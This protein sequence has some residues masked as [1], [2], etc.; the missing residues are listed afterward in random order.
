[1]R[2]VNERLNES[3]VHLE[4]MASELASELTRRQEMRH[5]EALAASR[6]LGAEV[7]DAH[8]ML[9]ALERAEPRTRLGR[10]ESRLE[11]LAHELEHRLAQHRAV[12]YVSPEREFTGWTELGLGPVVGYRASRGAE[13][14]PHYVE[15]EATFRGPEARVR[16]IQGAYI[17]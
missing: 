2:L 7:R 10:M 16:D 1:Q 11:P 12:P 15:F 13:P 9:E 5:A 14:R 4:E 17:P 3:V 6:H 8:V